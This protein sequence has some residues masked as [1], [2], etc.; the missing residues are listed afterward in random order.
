[1]K[2]CEV[3]VQCSSKVSLQCSSLSHYTRISTL[4]YAEG[5]LPSNDSHDGYLMLATT[6]SF[7]KH[8]METNNR[9]LIDEKVFIVGP[10]S[11]H[12][13]ILAGVI[14]GICSHSLISS[15]PDHLSRSLHFSL[16]PSYSDFLS[17]QRRQDNFYS[18]YC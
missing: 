3:S 10:I 12:G 15:S 7:D 14:V 5:Q 6:E 17:F 9:T 18:L 8:H 4:L 13:I 2:W 16:P 11:Y 1:M